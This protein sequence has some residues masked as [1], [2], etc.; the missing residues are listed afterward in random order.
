MDKEGEEAKTTINIIRKMTRRSTR[1]E[2]QKSNENLYRQEAGFTD[3]QEKNE[4]LWKLMATYIPV[5]KKSIQTAIVN[6]VEY[7]LAKNRFNFTVFHAYQAVSYSVR[8]RLIESFNDTN[9]VFYKKEVK[10][11]FLSFFHIFNNDSS[12]TSPLNSCWEG[13]CTMLW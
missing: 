3:N 4:K 8:D 9:Q 10:R 13:I 1:G 7:T 2:F 11:V 6:H 12:I 5:D